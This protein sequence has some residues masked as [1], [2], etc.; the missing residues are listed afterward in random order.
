MEEAGNIRGEF[1]REPPFE[2][3]GIQ[4]VPAFVEGGDQQ[5]RG[6]FHCFQIRLR[7]DAVRRSRW[8]ETELRIGGE[9]G[10]KERERGCGIEEFGWEEQGVDVFGREGLCVSCEGV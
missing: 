9:D 4:G 10:G 8:G 2:P 6:A 1:D 3:E 5:K 7:A